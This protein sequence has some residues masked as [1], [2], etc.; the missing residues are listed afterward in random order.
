MSSIKKLL[1]KLNKFFIRK[2]LHVNIIGYG[3]VGGSLGH[4]CKMRGVNYTVTDLEKKNGDFVYFD[5]LKDTIEYSEAN[6]EHN[7]YFIC[8]PTPEGPGGECDTSIVR[9][10]FNTLLTKCK[11]KN[12]HIIIKSTLVPGTTDSLNKLIKNRYLKV[13]F[14]PEFLTEANHLIDIVNENKIIIGSNNPYKLDRYVYKLLKTFYPKAPIYN[15]SYKCSELMKYTI[16]VYLAQKVHYFNGIK[17]ICDHLSVD[18]NEL[19]RLVTLDKRIGSSHTRV[20]GPD[21]MYGFG[22]SCLVKET[23]GMINLREKL[24]LDSTFLKKIIEQNRL[25]RLKDVNM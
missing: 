13:Y 6:N 8:V 21:G 19:I 7:V 11:S 4:L 20:P 16:N 9:S 24:H 12:T 22:G 23:K 10:V 14:Y 25:Y 18:Y 17:E 15:T 1:D 3:Y 5:N 2:K